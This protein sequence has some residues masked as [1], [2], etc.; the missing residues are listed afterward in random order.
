MYRDSNLFLRML[1]LNISEH[2][3]APEHLRKASNMKDTK[4]INRKSNL[5]ETEMMRGEEYFKRK[6]IINIFR[7]I[8]EDIKLMK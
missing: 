8:R 3:E 5:D 7:V 1:F 6:A 2:P 4:Q